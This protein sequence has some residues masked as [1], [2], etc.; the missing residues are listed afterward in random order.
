[1][2]LVLICQVYSNV[3][4]SFTI[5]WHYSN[6]SSRP[7]LVNSTSMETIINESNI[8]ININESD[9]TADVKESTLTL[10]NY[11]NSAEMVSGYYWC[12][13]QS[14]GTLSNPSHVVDI[15]IMLCSNEEKG[16]AQGI[17]NCEMQVD[18]FETVMTECADEAEAMNLYVE[19]V[20]LGLCAPKDLVA[21]P[22]SIYTD[23]PT[24]TR[25]VF[26]TL[27][28]STVSPSRMNYVWMIVGIAFGILIVI[29]VIMFIAI[30]Y[31]NHKKNKIKGI[32]AKFVLFILKGHA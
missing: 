18:L 11:S 30:V 15:S 28:Q 26:P 21:N 2:P 9:I 25:E 13:V 1:M 32:R 5:Q 8:M 19:K 29:I 12:T 17:D 6:S 23:E 16:H 31:L 4:D 3:N 22:T 10:T 27:D 14:S 20:Q 24:S 7:S